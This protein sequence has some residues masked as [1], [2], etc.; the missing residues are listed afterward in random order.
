M[1]SRKALSKFACDSSLFKPEP[2][3]DPRLVKRL[4][5]GRDKELRRGFETLKNE[6]DIH[7]KRSRHFDKVP[8][9]IHGESRSGKSHL[10]RRI[11]AEFPANTRRLQLLIPA[12][13][14]VE[15]LLVI[16]DIFRQLVG[17]FRERTQNERLPES[18]AGRPDIGIVNNLIERMLLFLNEAQTATETREKSADTTLEVGGEVSGLLGKF[19][20]K[21][22]SKDT[23]K[24]TRQVVLKAPTAEMLAELCGV[25]LE[26]LMALK[27]ADHLLVLVDDVDL[28]D[29]TAPTAQQ[30]RVQRAL[31][32]AALCTLHGQPGIDVLLTARSWFVYSGKDLTHLVDLT[33]SVMPA[34]ALMAIHD[35]H[36]EQ[37]GR[38]ARLQRFLVPE[39]LKAFAEE[40]QEL[41]GLPGVFLQHL[42]TAM[43]RF[44]DD[45]DFSE[46]DYQWFVGVF[47]EL[48]NSL[49]TR[50]EPG[51]VAMQAAL[52][53][54]RLEIQVGELNPFVGTAL[55]NLFVWQSYHNERC[56][57]MSPLMPQLFSESLAP[58][59]RPIA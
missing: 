12:R 33:Q 43:A 5:A 8:W 27:L 23:G 6:L 39:A 10:A 48:M 57:F 44:K 59:G 37:F 50:V 18:V 31:L 54:G 25:M 56:Y 49:R 52:Q 51:F 55:D 13:D 15:A 30:A 22:Q 35:K 28:L 32:T 9:V 42:Y 53:A 2:P 46:R 1:P 26:T 40:M 4:F 38:K 7:G 29:L 24:Q 21:F 14:R 36:M 58:K 17:L 19:V 41:N 20:G 45:D 11:L 47:R 34:E 3:T 16:A